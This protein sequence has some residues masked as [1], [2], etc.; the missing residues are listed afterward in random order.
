MHEDKWD[1]ASSRLSSSFLNFCP[2]SESKLLS[3]TSPRMKTGL[4][5]RQTSIVS[6]HV[7]NKRQQHTEGFFLLLGPTTA[8]GDKVTALIPRFDLTAALSLSLSWYL[9]AS[10]HLFLL[11]FNSL[12]LLPFVLTLLLFFDLSL[13]LLQVETCWV[14]FFLFFHYSN[15]DTSSIHL[16]NIDCK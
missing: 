12:F 1:P 6:G 2:V 15:H 16:W 11:W 7:W 8:H 9:S 4:V 14:Y 5:D 13:L 10:L 3:G